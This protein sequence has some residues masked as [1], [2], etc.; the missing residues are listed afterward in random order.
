MIIRVKELFQ[1]P[2]LITLFR[3]FLSV[4]LYITFT[5]WHNIT[6]I[7]Y[8]LLFIVFTAYISDILDGFLARKLNKT[9][10]LGRML[11]PI[12]DKIFIA[13]FVI[14]LWQIEFIS[15]FYL[16]IILCRDLFIILGALFFTSKKNIVLQ[17][18]YVGKITVFSIGIYLLSS[19]L[20]LPQIL[21]DVFYL[22][23][24]SL[25]FISLI[26]YYTRMRR[27]FNG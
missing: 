9:S 23:S 2:N 7:N 11:D 4:P 8:F 6:E 27:F 25:S 10:D 26:N 22:I 20:F 16:I 5:T 24:I 15:S 14:S 13:I 1:I 21:L 12:A 18:D 19:L 3:L 17:S